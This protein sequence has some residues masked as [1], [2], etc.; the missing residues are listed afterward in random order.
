[1][2]TNTFIDRFIQ[3]LLADQAAEPGDL[4]RQLERDG[5]PADVARVLFAFV[6]MAFAY[7]LLAPMGVILPRRFQVYDLDTRETG[8]G[9]L[10]D[11]PIF[12]AALSIAAAHLAAGQENL[13][14]AVASSSA[15][16]GV[17]RKLT[18]GGSRASGIHLTEPVLMGVPLSYFP[19]SRVVRHR[20]LSWWLDWLLQWTR[21]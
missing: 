17:V 13:V 15:E 12:A 8:S 9:L 16:M 2:D 18:A 14:R 20:T 11:E 21:R 3:V 5:V 1:M 7:A 4:L 6:P 10:Q 19:R